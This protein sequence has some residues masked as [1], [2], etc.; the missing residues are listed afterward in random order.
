MRPKGKVDTFELMEAL[1]S[2]R[3]VS[4]KIGSEL[5]LEQFKIM[6][7]HAT[8]L[9]QATGKDDGKKQ[10]KPSPQSA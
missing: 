10:K 5:T 9:A 1:R 7:Q 2:D 3:N 6:A 4:K 8:L